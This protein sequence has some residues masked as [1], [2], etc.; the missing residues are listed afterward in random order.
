LRILI[1]GLSGFAGN[2]LIEY[3][4]REENH[5][6][7]GIDLEKCSKKLGIG[8]SQLMEEKADLTDGAIADNMIERFKPDQVYHLAA[9]SS[10]KR[11]W[12]D[13]IGTFRSNVFGGINLLESIRKRKPGAGILVIC[14]AEEYGRIKSSRAIKESDKI[15][16]KNPYA[17]SK[18][19]M[20]F[21]S[22][23]YHGAYGLNI[24]VAR[25]FNHIGPGQSEGFV[26]SDFARQIAL[27]E[28][29]TQKP[30]IYVG[31]LDSSRDFL[32]V[33]DVVR[34]Y[35]HIMNRG[36]PGEVYNVCSGKAVKIAALLDILI[37]LS[38]ASNI[39]I[40]IDKNKF[41]PIDIEKIFGDNNKLISETG[42]QPEHMLEESLKDTLNWWRKEIDIQKGNLI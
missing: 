26:C 38:T 19:A 31:N 10:V 30:V 11:S 17:V 6:F 36:K 12:E 2:H 3:L 42:W 37:S 40:R 16:P 13:P 15:Y 4:S 27:I 18:S 14:T 9:Q 35:W 24:M 8:T 34:A 39:E 32:D 22:T 5:I 25:S 33:R 41:R 23:M 1:T 29:G 20:D 7:F 28:A 21:I